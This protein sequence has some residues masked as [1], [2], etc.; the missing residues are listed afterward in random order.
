LPVRAVLG[1]H[2]EKDIRGELFDWQ[3][4]QHPDEAPLALSKADLLALPAALDAFNGFY[5]T[6]GSLVVVS[7]MHLLWVAALG[8]LLLVGALTWLVVRVIRGWR[9]RRRARSS[10]LTA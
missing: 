4:P 10:V 1:G 8:A 9:R 5:T 6:Y 2:V 3:A 7:P